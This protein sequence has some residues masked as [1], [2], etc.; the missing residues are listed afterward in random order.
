MG[1]RLSEH[2]AA[3]CDEIGPIW[4]TSDAEIRATRYIMDCWRG[5]GL[6]NVHS[7]EFEFETWDPGAAG[8]VLREPPA[9]EIDCLPLLF[10]PPAHVEARL[11]DAGFG[12]EHETAALGG[13]LAGSI[14]LVAAFEPFTTPQPLA[15]RVSQ[16]AEAGAVA[17]VVV[18]P[19]GGRLLSYVSGSH[20]VEGTSDSAL[21]LP[22]LLTSREDGGRLRRRVNDNTYLRLQ[23]DADF[24]RGR[25][26]NTV[27]DIS[28]DIWPDEQIILCAHHDTVPGAPGANE[29]RFGGV[30]G[31]G[32][33][34]SPLRPA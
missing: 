13:E 21:P 17:V 32:G 7:E 31:H 6:S 27:A 29:T 11:L 2:L 25:S 16:L 1:S 26:L 18:S 8:A 22:A 20:W 30:R 33:C 34:Q 10:S 3:L 28:G 15:S 23:I 14:A 24:R 12:T 19:K 4:A 5:Q 9:H